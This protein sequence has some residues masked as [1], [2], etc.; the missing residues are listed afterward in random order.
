MH[1]KYY[2]ILLI[3]LLYKSEGRKEEPYLRLCI[4]LYNNTIDDNKENIHFRT[5]PK[6][7]KASTR[8]VSVRNLHTLLLTMKC[9]WP[10]I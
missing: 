5:T 9:S 3:L 8:V 4:S 2:L 1:V 6:Y 10:D 7:N